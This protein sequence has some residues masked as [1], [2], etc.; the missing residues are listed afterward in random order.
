MKRPTNHVTREQAQRT[1][2]GRL[3]GAEVPEVPLDLLQALEAAFP[4]RCY[5]AKTSLE[6]HLM[7]AGKVQLVEALRA[8]YEAQ[9][10]PD[11]DGDAYEDSDT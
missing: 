5:E 4:P 1:A 7:Y 6:E 8:T 2:S 3:Q 11:S 10:R 9:A